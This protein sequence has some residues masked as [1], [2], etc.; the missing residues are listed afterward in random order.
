MIIDEF[1]AYVDKELENAVPK[2]APG[3]ALAYTKPLLPSFKEVFI[4][5]GSLEIDNNSAEGSIRTF[6]VG[7]EVNGFF[8]LQPRE[9]NLVHYY[10]E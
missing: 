4:E 9:Q 6:V 3:K 10:I 8:L 2:S 1:I 7:R 5:D